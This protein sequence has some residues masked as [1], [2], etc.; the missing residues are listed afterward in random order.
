MLFSVL[1]QTQPTKP[2]K[3]P[4][5]QGAPPPKHSEVKLLEKAFTLLLSLLETILFSPIPGNGILSKSRHSQLQG[6]P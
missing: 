1:L 5:Y 3:D 4:L 6:T 2:V